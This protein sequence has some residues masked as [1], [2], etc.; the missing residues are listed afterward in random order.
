M[1]LSGRINGSLKAIEKLFH[2]V[3]EARPLAEH[4]VRPEAEME[5][6]SVPWTRCPAGAK[7]ETNC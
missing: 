4:S 1:Q 6:A 3:Q 2:S 5:S 7:G